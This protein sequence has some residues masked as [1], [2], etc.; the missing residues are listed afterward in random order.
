MSIM[1]S[2]GWSFVYLLRPVMAFAVLAYILNN[3]V[4]FYAVPWGNIS[5]KQMVY[6][7]VRH[8]ANLD[9]KPNIFNHDFKNLVLYAKGR[10]GASELNDLFVADTSTQGAN[11]I[12]LSKKGIIVTDPDSFKIQLQLHKGTIHNTTERGRN[13]QILNFDRYDLNLAL[14]SSGWLENKVLVD[15]RELSLRDLWNRIQ[16]LK[17]NGQPVH[18]EEVELSKKFSIPLTCI[19]FALAGA[20]LGLKSSRSGKSGG[21][22]LCALII[23]AYYVGLVSTQNLGA[24]GKLPSLLSVWIPNIVLLAFAVFVVYKAHREIPF[25]FLDG[26]IDFT[27][28]TVENIRNWIDLQGIKRTE[29]L[30]TPNGNGSRKEEIDRRAREILQKKLQKIKTS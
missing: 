2:S 23:M 7:I 3:G 28:S 25:A 18:R 16:E 26:V 15:N 1:K 9:I 6:D 12:I 14:P 30:K 10:N 21:F 22:V 4:I 29:R 24:V 13:Y 5:F 17:K 8:R 20:P 11:R 19:L 27:S